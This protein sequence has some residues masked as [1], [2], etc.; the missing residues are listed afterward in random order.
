[1]CEYVCGEIHTLIREFIEITKN[2]NAANQII[3]IAEFNQIS[4]SWD[5]KQNTW[6]HNSD[7]RSLFLSGNVA[8]LL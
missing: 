2:I 1:M 6:K 7:A 3:M 4:L 8:V 5:T